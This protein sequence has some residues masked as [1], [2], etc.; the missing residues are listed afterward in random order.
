MTNTL[1]QARPAAG[2]PADPPVPRKWFPPL[3]RRLHFYAGLFVGPFIFVVAVTGA[4]YALASP[5]ENLVYHDELTARTQGDPMTLARQIEAA[6]AYVG[7]GQAPVAVRPAP[8]PGDTTRVMYSGPDFGPSESR[9][10]F[11]DPASAAIQGELTSY[12]TSGALPLRTWI[13][14]FHRSLHLGDPGRLYSELAASWLGIIALAGLGLWI[15]RLRQ[16]RKKKDLIRPATKAKGY[17]RLASW[18]A[19][20]GIWVLAGALFLS[21]T[22]IT[23]SQLGGDNV[24][25]LRSTLNWTTPVVETS[26]NGDAPAA[27]G[28]E[29]H[30]G[31]GGGASSESGSANPA[32]F[33]GVLSIAQG[34]NVNTGQVEIKPPSGRGQ[35]WVVQEIHRS[36]PTEVDSVAIDGQTMQVLDRVDFADFGIAAK[37]ARWGI[38]IHMGSMFGLANQIVMFLLGSAIATL[39]VLGYRMWWK[40]RPTRTRGLAKAPERGSLATAPWWGLLLVVSVAGIV[41]IFLPL[42]GIT[43]AGFVLVD[44]LLGFRSRYQGR[45]RLVSRKEG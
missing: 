31:H 13:D 5:V 38:D 11:I 33:D 26:L 19:S 28:H 30:A 14:Q 34:A 21:A 15:T 37:L 6:N 42:L 24:S 9:A 22:G 23:W 2:K 25:A 43:L 18:H 41:G 7:G 1:D 20:A 3:L 35:A 16:T 44:V 17:R 4:L 45:A 32:T 8:E 10:V 39:V 36:Y 12:G 27:T 29:G 40:R